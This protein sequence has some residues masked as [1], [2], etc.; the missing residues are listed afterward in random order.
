MP[1]KRKPSASPA[2]SSRHSRSSSCESLPVA[3]AGAHKKKKI[4]SV[5][6]PESGPFPMRSHTVGTDWINPTVGQQVA[7]KNTPVEDSSVEPSIANRPTRTGPRITFLS[8]GTSDEEPTL[9][10]P[11]DSSP[12]PKLGKTN[13]QKAL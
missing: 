9:G 1:P 6:T 11:V 13:Q 10:V 8:D 7:K 3:A 5:D 4:I 2:K 12:E